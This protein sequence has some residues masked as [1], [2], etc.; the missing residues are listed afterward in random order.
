MPDRF[1]LRLSLFYGA[2]FVY[3]GISLPFMPVWLAAKGLD[4]REIGVVLAVPLVVRLLVV[5]PS[6]R[7]ADRFAVLRNAI[8]A[9]SITSV[10]GF[11]VIGLSAGF[12]GI[13]AAFALAAVALAPVLPLT[14]A[15]ALRG[16][17][18]RSHSYG[19]VR[20]WGSVTFIA[21]TLAGGVLLDVFGARNVI[22]AV[23]ATLVLMAAIALGLN[24]LSPEPA[25]P[26]D[27]RKAGTS[28]WRSP[29]FVV[30]VLGASLIQASHAVVLGFGT[31]QWSAK[32]IEGPVI[33]ALIAVGVL[34]EITLFAVS[35]RALAALGAVGMIVLGGLGGVARWIGMI[36]DPPVA[37]LALL[38][39]LHALSLGATHIGTM[40]FLSRTVPAGRAATAQ[41]DCAAAQGI[42][43]AVAMG[44]S[45]VLVA[46]LGNFAYA[47]MAALAAAG[48]IIVGAVLRFARAR[49]AT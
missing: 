25:E 20:L 2:F 32:G 16:L 46:A 37:A 36:F 17:Q 5:P 34:A 26:A 43:F 11:I 31:L 33:G 4:S 23:V 7:L 21:A 28:L 44:L 19:S 1:A 15:Y 14:D 8:V 6:T 47:V 10:A 24:R 12:A 3:A 22:W 40:H 18:G 48:A 39:C 42:V 29:A 35:G 38:Q 9:A 41:G 49:S 30:V 27:G 45:G 13:L